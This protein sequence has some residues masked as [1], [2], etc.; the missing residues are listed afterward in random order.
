MQE[1]RST[2]TKAAW[3]G[4]LDHAGRLRPVVVERIDKRAGRAIYYTDPG[5][6]T[7]IIEEHSNGRRFLLEERADGAGMTAHEIARR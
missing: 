4:R 3:E 7:G 2:A 1:D 5:Y 6:P